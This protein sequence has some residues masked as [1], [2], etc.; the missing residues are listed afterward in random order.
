M[1]QWKG[2]HLPSA[3]PSHLRAE[4]VGSSTWC[5]NQAKTCPAFG[6]VQTGVPTRG[7]ESIPAAGGSGV[8]SSAAPICDSNSAGERTLQAAALGQL[9]ND[10]HTLC[11][12]TVYFPPSSRCYRYFLNPACQACFVNN[13]PVL[14]E[15]RLPNSFL[16]F[17]LAVRRGNH[18]FQENLTQ[19]ELDSTLGSRV[20]MHEEVRKRRHPDRLH[21]KSF[22]SAFPCLLCQDVPGRNSA[23]FTSET[24]S[25]A[26]IPAHNAARGSQRTANKLGP[27][28]WHDLGLSS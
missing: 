3:T 14:S 10:K 9:W 22:A 19:R 16:I 23:G 17:L 24:A 20:R 2:R 5:W 15:Q 13:P 6:P 21:R 26:Q 28:L 4:Q 12:W 1:R 25:Q 11:Y 8:S 18:S 7:A 27:S